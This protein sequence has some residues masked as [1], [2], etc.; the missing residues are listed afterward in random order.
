[1]LDSTEN[2][3]FYLADGP[4]MVQA[5]PKSI[6]TTFSP[7]VVME[8]GVEGSID[9]GKIVRTYPVYFFVRA[10]QMANNDKQAVAYEEAWFH[11]QQ[12]LAWLRVRH[13]NDPT[14]TG[15]YARIDMEDPLYVQPIGPL[16]DGWVAVMIQFERM[17]LLNRCVDEDIYIDEC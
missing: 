1:M 3:R 11:A 15:E 6:A 10:E 4:S 8:N 5:M 9:S 14:E 16:E 17:E 2:R 13:E 12:F 7:C